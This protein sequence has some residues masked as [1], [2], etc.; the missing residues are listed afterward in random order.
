MAEQTGI[1]WAHSTFSPWHG[2]VEVSP[3]CDN[4]YARDFSARLGYRV[5]GK[6]A[7]R[8][9]FGDKHWEEPFR[10]HRRAERLGERR[11]VFC[12][13]MADILEERDDAEGDLMRQARHRLW[14]VI[15]NTPSLDWLLLTKRPQ[16]YRRLV[17]AEILA[18][19]NVWPGTTVESQDYQWRADALLDLACAGPRWVSYEPALGPLSATPGIAWYVVGGESGP[20]ARPM[21]LAWIQEILRGCRTHGA[22]CFVKQDSGR[23]PGQQGRIPD[24]SWIKEFPQ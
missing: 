3:G 9:F 13:S 20:A 10:W 12:A 14:F 17:P 2:C 5:W 7:A 23:A 4:C 19:P 11:R 15:L 16:N 18:R 8:R 1:T 24:I 6:D 22:A 21:D